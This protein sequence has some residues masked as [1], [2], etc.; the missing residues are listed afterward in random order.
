MTTTR[1]VRTG[2][3]ARKVGELF[4]RKSLREVSR[5]CR[6]P[7]PLVKK[8]KAGQV[9]KLSRLSQQKI[10]NAYRREQY[11]L[12]RSHNVSR[13]GFRRV[14]IKNL[15]LDEL[16]F[17][18]QQTE[19][20]KTFEHAVNQTRNWREDVDRERINVEDI[21]DKIDEEAESYTDMAAEI[22]EKN[23]LFEQ[24]RK[25]GKKFINRAG[26]V[27]TKGDAIAHMQ[28]IM[29]LGFRTEKDWDFYVTEQRPSEGW[30]PVEYVKD[31]KS[32]KTVRKLIED[33]VNP[34]YIEWQRRT[35][36]GKII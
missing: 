24:W 14:N 17:A 2:S 34:K 15:N 28:E 11:A 13:Q 12:A 35:T 6:L 29:A 21:F 19:Y 33:P 4:S 1:I 36:G 22:V 27:R 18:A 31:K 8:I 9:K 5:A 32:K 16:E 20:G 3:S 7:A 25:E 30:K 26:R 10:H 23:G